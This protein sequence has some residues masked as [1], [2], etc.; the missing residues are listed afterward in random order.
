VIIVAVLVMSPNW[1]V[2]LWSSPWWGLGRRKCPLLLCPAS[3]SSPGTD[4]WAQSHLGQENLAAVAG[5]DK[6]MVGT[7]WGWYGAWWMG[8]WKGW[9]DVTGSWWHGILTLPHASLLSGCR[10]GSPSFGVEEGAVGALAIHDVSGSQGACLASL[11]K[12]AGPG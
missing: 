12:E 10:L 3:G 11:E 9:D 6:L 7:G 2:K 4:S 5:R 8:W 1:G